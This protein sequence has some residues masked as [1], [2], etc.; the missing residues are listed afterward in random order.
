MT[1]IGSDV[2]RSSS[3]IDNVFRFLKTTG[4]LSDVSFD[5]TGMRPIFFQALNDL[6]NVPVP[7]RN[8]KYYPIILDKPRN[9]SENEL[10][11]NLMLK[12]KLPQNSSDELVA[13]E[14][15][16]EARYSAKDVKIAEQRLTEALEIIKIDFPDTYAGI[17]ILIGSFLLGRCPGYGG[18]TSSDI[19][20]VIWC[21]PE[22]VNQHVD[23]YIELIIHEYM[24]QCLFLDDMVNKIFNFNMKELED[25]QTKS[26]VLKRIRPYDKSF[27]SGFVAMVLIQTR[28]HYSRSYDDIYGSCL[29]CVEGLHKFPQALT[30]HGKL[31]LAELTDVCRSLPTSG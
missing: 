5:R 10:F 29:E 23:E 3:V 27:H 18:G 17:Q 14:A 4:Y 31:R 8:D 28:L 25:F 1:V 2:Y 13:I 30:Q 16:V 11:F 9:E 6:L 20:G 24:H 7:H 21:G 26:A 15:L 19:L 22:D 12:H